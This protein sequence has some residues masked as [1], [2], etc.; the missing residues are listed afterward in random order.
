MHISKNAAKQIVEEISTLVQ[1]NINLMDETGHI[2]ASCDA[3]RIG[4]F[5]EGAYK[6]IT[7][8]LEEYYITAELATATTKEG[9]NLPLELDGE[10][11]GVVGITGSYKEVIKMGKMLK[12]MTEILLAEHRANYHKLI[13]RRVKNA[14]FEE[15]LIN[16][17]YVNRKEL[18]ERGNAIGIDINQPRRV[19]I[20][21]IEGL[22]DC[23]DTNEGQ[24]IIAKF[25]NEVSAFLKKNKCDTYFRNKSRQV[26]L[27]RKM[28][29]EELLGAMQRL[30]D[31]AY[32]KMQINVKVGVD[33]SHP[34]NM[35]VA[36]LQAGRAFSRV[37]AAEDW[38]AFYDDLN[39]ELLLDQTTDVRKHEFLNKLFRNCSQEEM[40]DFLIMLKA[41]YK[42]NGSINK[43]AE[44]LFVHKNTLQYRLAKLS[45]VTGLDARRLSDSAT[46]Y[47]ASV[48]ASELGMTD[49]IY[50]KK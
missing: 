44:A 22:E 10:I 41:Y 25:E 47:L 5:H 35:H 6:I 2:I 9:L 7:E 29:D 31:Y 15:W 16:A 18:E 48:L 49:V 17:D 13:D 27:T 3:A 37:A 28:T 36:F 46:L 26:I 19:L 20:I 21:G 33:S 24:A 40:K 43:T 32:E 23:I 4:T 14:F 34:E 8:H 45:E 50:N 1:Q 11:V 38:I 12:K 39:L 42:H 30:K